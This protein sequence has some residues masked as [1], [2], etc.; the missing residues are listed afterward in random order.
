MEK[1]IIT[2]VTVE[3]QMRRAKEILETVVIPREKEF[4]R[5]KKI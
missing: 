5:R 4:Q 3:E 1:R 2:G